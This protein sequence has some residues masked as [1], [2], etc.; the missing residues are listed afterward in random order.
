[1]RNRTLF[2]GAVALL[3]AFGGT[4]FFVGWQLKTE[5]NRLFPEIVDRFPGREE[6]YPL[7]T[8]GDTL[9]QAQARAEENKT[10]PEALKQEQEMLRIT[11]SG[12]LQV[13]LKGGN[14]FKNLTFTNLVEIGGRKFYRF[15]AR[16]K[17]FFLIDPT[18]IVAIESSPAQP[19]ADK[20]TK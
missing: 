12:Q 8:D 5:G 6:S 17:R 19:P 13:Y 15:S 3:L 4:L 7:K 11:L 18:E 10:R 9:L 1:M 14:N 2:V 20:E 16:T